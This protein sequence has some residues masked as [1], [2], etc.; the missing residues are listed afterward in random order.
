MSAIDDIFEQAGI[1]EAAPKTVQYPKLRNEDGMDDLLVGLVLLKADELPR[2]G[3]HY[4]LWEG[5]ALPVLYPR[6]WSEDKYVEEENK[7]TIAQVEAGLIKNLTLD[8]KGNL[9][10]TSNEARMERATKYLRWR[11]KGE[12]AGEIGVSPREQSQRRAEVFA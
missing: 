6:T 4:V 11:Y 2:P 9:V 5:K 8:A 1:T 7:I 10:K 3:M 12:V